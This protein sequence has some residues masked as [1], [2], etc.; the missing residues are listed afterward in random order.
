MTTGADGLRVDVQRLDPEMPLPAYAHPGDAGID[1]HARESIV[2]PCGGGRVLMPTGIA[3]AIPLGWAGFVLPRSGL[4]LKH[5]LSVVN[6]PGLIDSA[7]RGELKVVLI[8]TDPTDDYEVARG[9]RIAQ[10]VLQRVGGVTWNEVDELSGD[11][12][13]GG[14]G[15]S[16]R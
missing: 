3:I 2:I 11:D 4:A 6:S 15:H 14:F 7:Y 1:L 8:N 13:G 5:G 9:D 10:L 12:R 16:G